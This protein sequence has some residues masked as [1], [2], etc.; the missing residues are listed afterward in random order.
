[1]KRYFWIIISALSFAGCK[2]VLYQDSAR[3]PVVKT[4]KYTFSGVA[5]LGSPLANANISAFRFSG[6]KKGELLAET[7][8]D[9]G[10]EYE[11]SFEAAYEGP[12]LLEAQ[13]GHYRDL[14]S[15]EDVVMDKAF[16]LSSAIPHTEVI[17]RTNINAWSTMAVAR[18]T[19]Q[20]GFWDSRTKDLSDKKR[21]EEDFAALSH[22]LSKEWMFVNI[23]K[24]PPLSS[25]DRIEEDSAPL[26]LYQS[27]GGLTWMVN[28]ANRLA[29]NKSAPLKLYELISALAK[30]MGDRQF[31]G[32]GAN[33]Q[34][35]PLSEGSEKFLDAYTLRDGLS[36]GV[37]MFTAKHLKALFLS[38]KGGFLKGPGSLFRTLAS[39]KA[40]ELF[41]ERDYA[42]GVEYV[43]P[44]ITIKI[45]NKS[46]KKGSGDYPVYRGAVPFSVEAFDS[47]AIAKIE[48]LEPPI[49]V[50]ENG[51]FLEIAD[52]QLPQWER[53]FD[54]CSSIVDARKRKGMAY[55]NENP[56]CICA[57]AEDA[58]ANENYALECF[59]RSKPVIEYKYPTADHIIN[60]TELWQGVEMV[61]TASSGYDLT[62]CIWEI[63]WRRERDVIKG[64]NLP[65]GNG[66]IEGKTCV[67]HHS[68][69]DKNMPNGLFDLKMLVRDKAGQMY[70]EGFGR[71]GGQYF[72]VWAEVPEIEIISPEN[73]AAIGSN[74]VKIH[75][76]K[77]SVA[78]LIEVWVE[79]WPR[80]DQRIIKKVRARPEGD[81][82]VST[83]TEIKD[84]E[85]YDYT[86]HARADNGSTAI[87][88]QRSFRIDQKPPLILGHVD[89]VPQWTYLNESSIYG[90]D[91][92]TVDI[93][94]G[95]NAVR[96]LALG[97]KRYFR[98]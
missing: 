57:K 17:S 62:E 66:V 59:S 51:E 97:S 50:I 9:E 83:I 79:Y 64:F 72:S 55:V 53:A 11:F 81:T 22:F 28:E 95:I 88:P 96:F 77:N 60:Y 63:G 40:P 48:V 30:D 80:F 65:K 46:N 43:R 3:S 47:S 18:V 19:A 37:A 41:A 93:L 84:G 26:R 1:M 8:S 52:G 24:T 12:I 74:E 89:D 67:V 23:A 75:I 33:E 2:E 16:P 91:R 71:W 94:S 58:F 76:K 5:H 90:V 14:M 25:L 32:L 21:I 68:L 73:F 39:M 85:L 45:D 49:G 34:R 61:A 69:N 13:G 98:L 36:L 38:Q 78:R 82:W 56:I 7:T 87:I 35:I 92:S 54:A 20:K 29:I 10:G 86:V 15:S 6:L 27:H 70:E 44:K 42:N 31:N 4:S